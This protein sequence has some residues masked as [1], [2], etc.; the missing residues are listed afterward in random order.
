[1]HCPKDRETILPFKL[2]DIPGT[3][4]MIEEYENIPLFMTK[5]HYERQ[6]VTVLQ[7]IRLQAEYITRSCNSSDRIPI[8]Q[9]GRKQEYPMNA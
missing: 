3:I 4:N 1:M 2:D 6:S 9:H 8:M 5:V 7:F